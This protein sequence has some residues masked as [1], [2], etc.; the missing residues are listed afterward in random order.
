MPETIAV[1]VTYYPNGPAQG[2]ACYFP[3]VGVPIAPLSAEQRQLI[4][5]SG[6][7][8]TPRGGTP[9][10]SA[11]DFGLEQLRLS[12][13]EGNKLMLLITDGIPTFS[14]GCGGNGQARVDASD[15]IAD[16]TNATS[17]DIR[18]FVIGSPGSEAAR[19]EL[20]R[21]AL[22]GLTS[23]DGCTHDGP[24][25]CHFDM[26]QEE[27]FAAALNEA[28][29]E[30]TARALACDYEIPPAPFGLDLKLDAI[31]VSLEAGD[32]TVLPLS[33]AAGNGCAGDWQVSED[34]QTINICP[35]A[36]D[37]VQNALLQD[38]EARIQVRFECTA[39]PT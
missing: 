32:G 23:P 3:D 10:H 7:A 14:I 31:S 5:A 24:E 2:P 21:M 18:T 26:T 12:D 4:R 33:R 6:E 11:Y 39:N 9:T 38:P 25:F 17:D 19:D 34:G 22:G 28:L 27:D 13:I 36:C 1:G 16:V 35:D 8:V 37:T 30:I 29:R 15:L 20:S